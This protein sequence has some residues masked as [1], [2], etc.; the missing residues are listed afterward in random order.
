MMGRGLVNIV[1]FDLRFI[2][3]DTYLMRERAW[4]SLEPMSEIYRNL[5]TNNIKDL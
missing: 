3:E 5:A 1:H 4:D 2:P